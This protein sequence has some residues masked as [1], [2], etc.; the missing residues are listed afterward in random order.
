MSFD[1]EKE[2][3]EYANER[4]SRQSYNSIEKGEVP[5]FYGGYQN[6]YKAGFRKALE[7][8]ESEL[9]KETDP[10]SWGAF[11]LPTVVEI[12]SKLREPK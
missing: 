11:A 7:L 2:S 3:D 9:K 10:N 4:W 6:S 1:L 12:I 5:D 8:V